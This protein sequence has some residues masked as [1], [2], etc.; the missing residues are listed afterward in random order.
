[1]EVFKKTTPKCNILN[2]KNKIILCS[3][4]ALSFDVLLEEEK[5][6]L[7][8]SALVLAF[9]LDETKEAMS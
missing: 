7:S 8:S 5:V 2:T 6:R 9:D 3:F 4:F 1:M